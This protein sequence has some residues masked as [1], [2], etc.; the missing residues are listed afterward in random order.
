MVRHLPM[1]GTVLRKDARLFW[2]FAVLNGVLIAAWQFPDLVARLGPI[3]GLV[4][5]SIPFATVLLILVV[6]YEDAILSLTHDWLVR[7]LSG[8]TLLL[9]KSA[10]VLLS[11]IAPAVLGGIA[12]NLY[13]GRSLGE[14][15]LA[16]VSAGASAGSLMLILLVAAMTALTANIRQAIIVLLAAVLVVAVLSMLILGISPDGA[17]IEPSGS[18][19]VIVR[20]LEVVVS[21]A[22]LSALWMQYRYRHT[23]ATRFIVAATVAGGA[24]FL[25]C[26][27][28]PRIFAV[29]K[30]FSN[31]PAIASSIQ[32]EVPHY[33]FPVRVLDAEEAASQPAPPIASDV[34]S[35]KARERAGPGAIA[36]TTPLT[37]RGVPAGY[38][39]TLSAA[40]LTYRKNGT[41]VQT[42]YSAPI[43]TS[44]TGSGALD[45]NQYWL[46]SRRDFEKLRALDDVETHLDYSLSLLAPTAAAALE[47]DGPRV[48]H[49]GIGY[50][51]AK[52]NRYIAAIDVD[53][54]KA[55]AQPAQLVAT[56]EGAPA[57]ES[58]TSGKL[59]FTPAVLDFW[60]GRQHVVQLRTQRHDVSHVNVTAFAAHAHFDRH[61][62]IP[63][64]LGGPLSTCPAPLP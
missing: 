24:A 1:L 29:Q 40:E 27:T 55:G 54:F 34:Y 11:I 6:F 58:R 49:P 38:R 56:V 20:P 10:F 4:R 17:A 31:D 39:L 60:G 47:V 23:R 16:G 9:A 59:D 62:T 5:V 36:F 14:A 37:Q 44:S 12:N 57:V 46:L 51:S 50:C 15:L 64:V 21:L 2:Q 52:F 13:E 41:V 3:A 45:R 48:F 42:L 8:T 32:L 61:V 35:E 22:A 63:G 53:C 18:A 43:E 28:W 25:I 26:M 33:C 30:L 19:W 7:P